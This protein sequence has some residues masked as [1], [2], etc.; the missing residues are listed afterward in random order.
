MAVDPI[1][2][3]FQAN[4]KGIQQDLN[5][6]DKDFDGVSSTAKKAGSN[7]EREFQRVGKSIADAANK[8][9]TLG[10]TIKQQ[11]KITADFRIELGR[12]KNE[13][14]KAGGAGTMNGQR[15]KKSMDNL[16]VAINDNVQ[17]VR[18][19]KIDKRQADES[20]RNLKKVEAQLKKQQ[21]QQDK[22]QKKNDVLGNTFKSLGT[23]IVAAFAVERIIA[24]TR[25]SIVL[26]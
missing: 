10:S 7:I 4:I 21:V 14:D 5:R 1:I 19:L 25:E 23:K 26:A 17:S 13:F 22:L 8:S 24:F 15:I 11:E 18:K 2:L 16:K 6:L 3:E 12:L 9:K 20:V